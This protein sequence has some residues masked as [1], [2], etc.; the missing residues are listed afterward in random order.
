M[1]PPREHRDLRRSLDD[2]TRLWMFGPL[3][4]LLGGSWGAAGSVSAEKLLPAGFWSA[5]T[6]APTPSIRRSRSL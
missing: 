3:E 1:K 5:A 2:F 4:R 6:S